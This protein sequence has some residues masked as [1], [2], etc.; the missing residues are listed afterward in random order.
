MTLSSEPCLGLSN[1]SCGTV[2][3]GDCRT[4]FERWQGLLP[5]DRQAFAPVWQQR[6]ACAS[7]G[8][9]DEGQGQ[10]GIIRAGHLL[11]RRGKG[12]AA[13]IAED[14]L[15]ATAAQHQAGARGGLDGE[16]ALV[17]GAT[18]WCRSRR[19]HRPSSSPRRAAAPS[20]SARRPSGRSLV[21]YA[22]SSRRRTPRRSG[23]PASA[24]RS[25]RS[26][27]HPD[28]EDTAGI[29]AVPVAFQLQADLAWTK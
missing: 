25:R 19:P 8:L 26:Y 28:A 17:V 18:P 11:N 5:G 14:H 12:M 1:S 3:H 10:R 21:R 2:E 13:S 7:E 24:H 15:I 4:C 20:S 22:P 29:S 9:H 16:R 23:R 27:T 6:V